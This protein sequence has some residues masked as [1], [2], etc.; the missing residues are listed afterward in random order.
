[1]QKTKFSLGHIFWMVCLDTMRWISGAMDATEDAMRPFGPMPWL[2]CR[3]QSSGSGVWWEVCGLRR[4]G[5]SRPTLGWGH[6][7]QD[8]TPALHCNTS[9]RRTTEQLM[10]NSTT[11]KRLQHYYNFIGEISG[12]TFTYLVIIY[13]WSIERFIFCCVCNSLK[14]QSTRSAFDK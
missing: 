10:Q 6:M 2:W 5:D 14:V 11:F 3:V 1:M 9:T 13:V 4:G 8:P 12:N 7:S